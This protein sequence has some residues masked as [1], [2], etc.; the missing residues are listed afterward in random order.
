LPYRCAGATPA[1][2]SRRSTV[3]STT[4]V[5]LPQAQLIQMATAHFVSHLL[6]AAAQLNL[7]DFFADSPKTAEELAKLTATD[8]R[9]FYRLMRTLA[10]LGLFT[11]DAGHR[12]SLRP[13]GEALKSGTLGS[14]RGAV[15]T[16]TGD[17]LTKSLGQL[18]YSVQTGKTG[19]EKAFGAPL[20]EWLA[21]HPA[22]ASMFSE[23]MV[24]FH[25]AEP[26]AVAAAYDFSQFETIID[27]GGATGNLLTAILARHCGPHGILFDLPHVVSDAPALIDE[28]G[29]TAHISIKAGNFFENVPPG[30][31]LICYPTSFTIGAKRS[32]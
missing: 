1:A 27:V 30:V 14:V 19:F 13:L 2:Q 23:T 8:V 29:L 17:L 9:S 3:R 16:L 22:E 28:R 18:H 15:L 7:A 21:N 32:A 26:A 25:G 12:F 6:F 10:S 24:G 20:F 11:E 5:E 4:E 31:M